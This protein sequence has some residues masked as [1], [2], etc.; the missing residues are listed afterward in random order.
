MNITHDLSEKTE[1]AKLPPRLFAIMVKN[2]R[3]RP[4]PLLFS[5]MRESL[6]LG[7]VQENII[8]PMFSLQDRHMGSREPGVEYLIAFFK[9]SV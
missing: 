2:L 6:V 1:G 8:S 5:R 4:P 7:L 3:P 9:I